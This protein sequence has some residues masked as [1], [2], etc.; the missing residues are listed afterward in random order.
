MIHVTRPI[1]HGEYNGVC[2]GP[3]LLCLYGKIAYLFK[4]RQFFFH[5]SAHFCTFISYILAYKSDRV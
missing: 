2:L 3:S 1:F 4:I 5:I